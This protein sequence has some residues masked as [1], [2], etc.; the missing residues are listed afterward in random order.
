VI[1]GWAPLSWDD[2]LPEQLV[3]P[4]DDGTPHPLAVAAAQVLMRQLAARELAGDVDFLQPAGGK[5]FGVLAVVD[6][7]G[8]LGFLRGFSG[9]MRR[10]WN[11]PGFVPPLFDAAELAS[12]WPNGEAEL[13]AMTAAIATLEGTARAELCARRRAH[14]RAL[15]ARIQ[16]SYRIVD[17]RGRVRTNAEIFAPGAAPGG[18]GDCAGPKL[19]G[20]AYAAGL[21]PLA[22]AELWWGAPLRERAHASFHAPCERKCGPI[23]RHMLACR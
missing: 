12:F 10:R 1:E 23:L 21:R 8:T 3:A 17:G 15:W 16:A 13:E 6:A 5:M 19:L 7:G 9:M 18:A 22:L 2:G 4:A 14:S 11:V 20:A